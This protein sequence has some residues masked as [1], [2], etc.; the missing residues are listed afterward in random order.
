MNEIAKVSLEDIGTMA[1]AVSDSGLFGLRNEAAAFSLM[2]IAQ[3]EGIHPIKAATQYHIIDGKPSLRSDAM[4]A[5][6]QAAGGKIR[7]KER[8]AQRVTLWLSHPDA[9]EIEVTW[10][11][12]R[13]KDAG[14]ANKDTWKRYPAQ[15]LSARCISEGVR[16][17]Y[18]AC[19]GGF[20]TPEEVGDFGGA[21]GESS[22]QPIKSPK[23]I[24]GGGSAAPAEAPA[25]ITDA[26]IVRAPAAES[27]HGSPTLAQ[28]INALKRRDPDACAAFCGWMRGQ[29]W[30]KPADVPRE[31]VPEALWKMK[32]IEDAA[33][34]D[35]GRTKEADNG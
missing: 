14:L 15:M 28:E 20:Y 32:E 23:E 10:D 6:F 18:P 8:T 16:A 24:H 27:A 35:A 17:L 26:E 33:A 11:M 25:E 4:L 19:I 12:P 7:W 1:K 3:A 30:N 21:A 34:T 9:G 5:R 13:A 22:P 2:C 31:R 29:G